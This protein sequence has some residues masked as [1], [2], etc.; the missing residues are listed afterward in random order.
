MPESDAPMA[1]PPPTELASVFHTYQVRRDGEE[2]LY[3][4]DPLV[5]PA[6]VEREVW[7]TFRERGFE[8]TLRREEPGDGGGLPGTGW[9]LVA[10]PHSVGPDG[11]P[12][13]NVILG[14][15]TVISTLLVGAIE[16]YRIDVMA[17]P[18]AALRA[19]PFVAAILGVLAIHESGHY[20]ASRYHDVDASLPYF[21]PVPTLIGT[22][23][24][25]IKM[26]GRIP[27]R[28]ALF[29]IG[30]A[31]P[32]AG[33]LATVVVTAIGLQLDPLPAQEAAAAAASD[34]GVY[35]RFNDP[36]LLQ[37]IAAATGTTDVLAQ[38]TVHPV[39]FGGWVGMLITFLNLLPVGQLDGGHIVRSMVG[40]RQKLVARAV[41]GALLA[42]A[43]YLF[44]VEEVTSSVGIWVLWGLMAAG[45]AYVGPADPVADESLDRTRMAIGVLTFV[46][47]ILCFTPIPFEIVSATA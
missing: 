11:I 9:V 2:V 41:P 25:V 5:S 35:I 40:D 22:M 15:L 38:G 32:I 44:F 36:P 37:L 30:A 17:D 45:L 31:G 20:V 7:E 42:L 29:D 8:P 10:E 46:V 16:W 19:W 18:L 13:T 4:G 33:L 3:I 47:G 21:I 14:I 28:K 1:A 26:K 43:G 34:S 6:T 24:A 23:G 39:V 27:S 12:W